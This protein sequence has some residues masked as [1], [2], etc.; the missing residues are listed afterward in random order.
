[1]GGEYLGRGVARSQKGGWHVSRAHHLDV[2]IF[3]QV[4][5]ILPIARYRL[6]YQLGGCVTT[7][8]SSMA[9]V[10]TSLISVTAFRSLKIKNQ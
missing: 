4:P 1:M 9:R 10:R 7:I 5:L 6:R 8:P 2:T 3:R